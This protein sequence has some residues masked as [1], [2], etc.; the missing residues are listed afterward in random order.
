LSTPFQLRIP[1]EI[2]DALL[3]QAEAEL[4]NECCGMLAGVRD[5][6]IGRVMKRYP[7]T[8][9]AETPA[10]RY[11]AKDRELF[12]A[13]RDMRRLQ[14]V[15]LAIYHSHP[16]S[17]PVPSKTDLARGYPGSVYLIISMLDRPPTVRGWWLSE[18]AYEEAE[19][20]CGP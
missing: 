15:Q 13:D 8:N 11:D 1:R 20:A 6:D 16:T 18:S 10:T 12:D 14:L 5:G 4:P 9:V 7:Y 3:A 2:F 19:W 17:A